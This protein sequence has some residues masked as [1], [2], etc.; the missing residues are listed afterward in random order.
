MGPAVG[1]SVRGGERLATEARRHRERRDGLTQRRKDAK[2][3]WFDPYYRVRTEP[4]VIL[5]EAKNLSCVS[6]CV[7]PND[8]KGSKDEQAL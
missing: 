5:S 7:R 6:L 1:V 4:R 3:I 8:P 2:V